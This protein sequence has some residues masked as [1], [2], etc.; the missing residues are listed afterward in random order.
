MKAPIEHNKCIF[1]GVEIA[2]KILLS[3]FSNSNNNN[4]NNNNNNKD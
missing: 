3:T 2:D 4:N 1:I